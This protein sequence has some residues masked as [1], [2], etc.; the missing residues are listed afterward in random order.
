MKNAYKYIFLIFYLYHLYNL[1]SAEEQIIQA[2]HHSQPELTGRLVA[3]GSKHKL[4]RVAVKQSH[5][6]IIPGVECHR[7]CVC[8]GDTTVMCYIKRGSVTARHTSHVTPGHGAARALT[9]SRAK[10][11]SIVCSAHRHTA[12]H[13]GG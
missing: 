7:P 10:H 8:D 1:Q 3:C 5:L 11:C 12:T 9:L 4:T 13:A 2:T 6:R